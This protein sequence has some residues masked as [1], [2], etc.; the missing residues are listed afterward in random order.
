M[1]MGVASQMTEEERDLE[2]IRLDPS[3]PREVQLPKPRGGSTGFEEL[4]A[5]IVDLKGVARPGIFGGEPGQWREWK[6][7]FET[8]AALL[9]LD[10]I[11]EAIPNTCASLRTETFGEAL[12]ARS[13][14]LY[15]ILAQVCSGKAL[16]VIRTSERMNGVH[17]W[18]LLLGSVDRTTLIHVCL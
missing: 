3:L 13:R 9:G 17:A 7:K 2:K 11:L 10:E 6:F 1:M 15:S 4:S 16:A 8:T 5:K 14:L 18:A 12:R